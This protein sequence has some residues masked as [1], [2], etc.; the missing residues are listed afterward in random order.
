MSTKSWRVETTDHPGSSLED[1]ENEPKWTAN[2]RF[3]IG[4]KGPSGQIP[5]LTHSNDEW[6][7]EDQRTLEAWENFYELRLRAK[8]GQLVNFRDVI[9]NQ[10]VNTASSCRTFVYNA[11]NAAILGLPPTQT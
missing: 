1:V 6:T 10:E 2:H 11:L 4:Y 3:R 8:H 7:E 5:G 9:Q